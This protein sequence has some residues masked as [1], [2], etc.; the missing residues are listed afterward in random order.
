MMGSKPPVPALFHND[1][2]SHQHHSSRIRSLPVGK[3][4]TRNPE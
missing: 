4:L 1:G 3:N 2:G